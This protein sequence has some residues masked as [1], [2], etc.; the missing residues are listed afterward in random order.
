[1]LNIHLAKVRILYLL[2]QG[3]ALPTKLLL[4]NLQKARAKVILF[5][6]IQN[7]IPK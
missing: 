3:Y 7:F 6:F 5:F 2:G 4:R 1:L